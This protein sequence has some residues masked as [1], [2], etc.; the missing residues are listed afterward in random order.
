MRQYVSLL[1]GLY[2]ST[3]FVASSP[4]TY[5]NVCPTPGHAKK[6]MYGKFFV[7]DGSS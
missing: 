7:I 3:T 1:M 4:G 2:T 5:W 6:D